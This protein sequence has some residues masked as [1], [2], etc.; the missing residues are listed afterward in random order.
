[1]VNF[2]PGLEIPALLLLAG[3]AFF[4]EKHYTARWTV[5]ANGV[6]LVTSFGIITLFDGSLFSWYLIGSVVASIITVISYVKDIGLFEGLY[7]ILHL[8]YSSKTIL[9]VV[10]A[11]MF[12]ILSLVFIP[13]LIIWGIAIYYFGH[14]IP[15]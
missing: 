12:G 5:A 14:S 10:I 6:I 7:K 13:I 9:G 4:V 1:M 11:A 15:F 8:F 2:I 3:M